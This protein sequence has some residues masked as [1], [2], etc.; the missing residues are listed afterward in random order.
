VAEDH[1]GHV[2][3]LGSPEK[4]LEAKRKRGLFGF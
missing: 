1:S 2:G 3:S 4:P